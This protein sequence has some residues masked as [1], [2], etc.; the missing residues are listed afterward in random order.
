MNLKI[1]IVLVILKDLTILTK[2]FKYPSIRERYK[3]S[4][5]IY[6]DFK[7]LFKEDYFV[8]DY[9]EQRLDHFDHL[10][11][12]TWKQVRRLFRIFNINRKR[13]II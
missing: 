13:I 2:S 7:T 3:R 4:F 8:E 12:K 11:I 6:G 10:S 1:L 9:F 5:S